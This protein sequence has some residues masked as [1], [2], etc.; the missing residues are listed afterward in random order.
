[1]SVLM[2]KIC[3]V[4]YLLR[5]LLHPG[6]AFGVSGALRSTRRETLESRR[7]SLSVSDGFRDHIFKV[8]VANFG[9]TYVFFVMRVLLAALG[10]IFMTF[11]ALETSLKFH[12]F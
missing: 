2:F 10:L 3:D 12:E 8:V 6:G 11:G 1:M 9:A 7:G 5:P 4:A